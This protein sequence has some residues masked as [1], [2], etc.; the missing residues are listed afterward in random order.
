MVIEDSGGDEETG[1]NASVSPPS[2]E[3]VAP[4]ARAR[5]GRRS[6]DR[7]VDKEKKTPITFHTPL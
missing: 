6:V 3:S 4:S 5:D 1:E 2:R 7:S